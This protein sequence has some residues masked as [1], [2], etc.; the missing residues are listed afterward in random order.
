MACATVWFGK[1]FGAVSLPGR[2]KTVCHS[3]VPGPQ[4]VT[5]MIQ[6]RLFIVPSSLALPLFSLDLAMGRQEVL[7]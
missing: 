3:S 5:V 6:P 7:A 1:T 2:A 4:D